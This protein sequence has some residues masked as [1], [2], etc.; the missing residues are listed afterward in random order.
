MMAAAMLMIR[1]VMKRVLALLAKPLL[2]IVWLTN[3]P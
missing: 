3:A 1:V 2:A